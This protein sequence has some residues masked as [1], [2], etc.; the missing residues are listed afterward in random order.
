MVLRRLASETAPLA[1]YLATCETAPEARVSGT[2]VFLTAQTERVPSTLLHNLK[3]NK[4][5]HQTV[6]L[7]RVVTENIS[8][9]AGPDRIKARELGA[10]FWQIEARFGFAQTPSVARELSRAEILG[11]ALDPSQLSF[12]VGRVNVKPSSR[13]GMARWRCRRGMKELDILLTRYVDE[14]FRDA[15]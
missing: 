13:P 10:G 9:V 7:V 2:A 6:L 4:V 1:N 8:R 3:H 14:R 15:T 12:F 11:L 5:L